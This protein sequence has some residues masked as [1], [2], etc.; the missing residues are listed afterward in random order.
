MTLFT[1]A[2]ASMHPPRGQHPVDTVK[3]VDVLGGHR[4]LLIRSSLSYQGS[5]AFHTW[6]SYEC[7]D[8]SLD[9][10]VD[11]CCLQIASTWV[12][13]SY[14]R[15]PLQDTRSFGISDGQPGQTLHFGFDFFPKGYAQDICVSILSVRLPN[16]RLVVCDSYDRVAT[17]DIAIV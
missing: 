16:E 17:L 10:P 3:S 15:V 11:N 8:W 5:E 2:A 12:Q 7:T 4:D 9:G 1:S 13:F 14:R 6:H